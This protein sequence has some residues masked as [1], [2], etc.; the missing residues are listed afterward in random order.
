MK[1]SAL[2]SGFK[3]PSSTWA[4]DA[5]RGAAYNPAWFV[6]CHACNLPVPKIY[7][8]CR[9]ICY[10]CARAGRD[11][12]DWNDNGVIRQ[13]VAPLIESGNGHGPSIT[14]LALL[15][16]NLERT[17]PAAFALALA[18]LGDYQQQA[19]KRHQQGEDAGAIG[20]GTSGRAARALLTRSYGKLLANVPS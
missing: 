7:L 3:F 1:R 16:K 5:R 9:R 4:D 15:A 11:H 19:V 10:D 14:Q 12:R 13:H 6:M 20:R 17:D 2:E 18:R 8:V